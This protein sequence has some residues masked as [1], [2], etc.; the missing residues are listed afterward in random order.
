MPFFI[1]VRIIQYAKDLVVSSDGK[2]SV[3][4]GKTGQILAEEMK[5][6]KNTS[7]HGKKG[8][9]WLGQKSFEQDII[10]ISPEDGKTIRVGKNRYCGE[11]YIKKGIKGLTVINKVE[12]ED[13]LKGVLPE[14]V[15]VFWPFSLLKAQAIASR[16][17]AVFET[18]RNKD[19]EYDL[20][21]D[22]FS[23]VYGR[24]SSENRKTNRA[25]DK[26]AGL[27]LEA[28]GAVLP[29]FFHSCCGGNTR[30]AENI[31]GIN[32]DS[33][34]GVKCPW[35]RW[36]PYFSWKT[37][38]HTKDI[39]ERFKNAGYSFDRIDDIRVGKKDKNGFLLFVSVK[40]RG[41]WYDVRVKDFRS[42]VGRSFLKSAKFKV[43]KYPRFYMF[44]GHGWGHGVGMCLWGAFGL[45]LRRWSDEKILKYYYPGSEIR[46]LDEVVKTKF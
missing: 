1:R 36:T 13:Y 37:K 35:C 23:Q 9:I 14:E 26:T 41:K 28:D 27:I 24:R 42:V 17:F 32:L 20:T 11:L 25:V 21:G 29:A 46:P 18:L 7:V 12:V 44:Y 31:W 6:A 33:L 45:S 5:L 43:K 4:S 8:R 2:V 38:I 39:L 34:K 30:N 15:Y 16:S 19:K 22:T 3:F 40:C 10:R